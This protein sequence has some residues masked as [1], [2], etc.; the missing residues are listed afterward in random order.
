[1]RHPIRCNIETTSK[2]VNATLGPYRIF[3]PTRWLKKLTLEERSELGRLYN[4]KKL[5]DLRSLLDKEI[6][7]GRLEL[8]KDRSKWYILFY[9][10]KS[11]LPKLRMDQVSDITPPDELLKH[12][13]KTAILSRA[14]GVVMRQK[15]WF[16]RKAIMMSGKDGRDKYGLSKYFLDSWV[17]YFLSGKIYTNW[18]PLPHIVFSGY[19]NILLYISLYISRKQSWI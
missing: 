12:I 2:Y 17:S 4:N 11:S 10:Q 6:D 14:Y 7:S 9:C 3:D 8:G 19:N 5:S 18:R 16:S 15:S 1:M 13:S